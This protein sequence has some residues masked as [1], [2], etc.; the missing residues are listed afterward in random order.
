M[1]T[2][3]GQAVGD[4][5]VDDPVA[6]AEAVGVAVLTHTVGV[7]S[8]R[9]E[10]GEGVGG[11]GDGDIGGRPVGSGTFLD[12]DFIVVAVAGPGDGSRV[13]GVGGASDGRTSATSSVA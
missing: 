2:A 10:T 11:A 5:A 8:G 7:G 12:V 3:A 6:V 13:V 9:T 4:E 1:V